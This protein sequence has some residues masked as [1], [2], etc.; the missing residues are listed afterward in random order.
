MHCGWSGSGQEIQPFNPCHQVIS[1]A[2]NFVII[3][4]SHS[5]Q[6]SLG[7]QQPSVPS[8]KEHTIGQQIAQDPLCPKSTN[9]RELTS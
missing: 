6:A 9:I 7:E 8:V 2:D 3:A 1:S 4:T 5:M